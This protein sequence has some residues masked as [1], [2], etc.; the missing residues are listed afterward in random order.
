[1]QREN[2]TKWITRDNLNSKNFTEVISNETIWINDE[3][4]QWKMELLWWLVKQDNVSEVK[5]DDIVLLLNRFSEEHIP[6]YISIIFE[7]AVLYFEELSTQTT[8]LAIKIMTGED[9]ILHL[10]MREREKLANKIKELP[11]HFKNRIS[12]VRVSEES[13]SEPLMSPPHTS[14]IRNLITPDNIEILTVLIGSAIGITTVTIQGIKLWL[15]ERASRKI[16]IRHKDFEVEIQ[17]AIS[18]KAMRKTLEMAMEI[19]EALNKD[20]VQ[21]IVS[22]DK[23]SNK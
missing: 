10:E 19:R 2:E 12:N 1:M 5:E 3:Y 20:N 14:L 7:L 15:D 4:C 8:E 9:I 17:G 21:I 16:K 23:Y 11:D 18:E 6:A 22:D 13:I